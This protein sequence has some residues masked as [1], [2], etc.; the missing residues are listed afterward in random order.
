MGRNYAVREEERVSE[1]SKDLIMKQ[2][3]VRLDMNRVSL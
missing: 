3:I 1:M 2:A